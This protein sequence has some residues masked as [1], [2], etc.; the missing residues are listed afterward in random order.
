MKAEHNALAFSW[1]RMAWQDHGADDA[2]GPVLVCLHGTG[3]DAADWEPMLAA[4]PP[5][6]RAVCPEFC[7]HGHSDTPD[8]DFTLTDLASDVCQ[9]LDALDLPCPVLVGHSLGGMVAMDVAARSARVAG[10]VL[11]EG[12]TRLGAMGQTFGPPHF[13]GT[14]SPPR[15]AEI[16]AKSEATRARFPADRWTRFWHTVETFDGEPFLRTT[17]LLVLQVYGAAGRF[18]LTPAASLA[19]PVRPNIAWHWVDDAGHYLPH[20]RPVEVAD[21]CGEFLRCLR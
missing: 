5:G 11:L 17:Q 1:G 20:E 8:S 15:I 21:L 16:A 3:C 6:V 13:Y 9:F 10:L 14:L 18:S 12:W 2:S 4:L 19:V 7:G